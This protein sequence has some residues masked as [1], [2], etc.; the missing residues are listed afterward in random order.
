MNWKGKPLVTY[1]AIIK[2]IGATKTKK[3]LNVTARLDK[4]EYLKGIK[5][6][7]EDMAK[8]HIESHDLHPKWNYTIFPKSD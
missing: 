6:T 5:F 7:D 2:L 8:L 4:S 1:E 3:G